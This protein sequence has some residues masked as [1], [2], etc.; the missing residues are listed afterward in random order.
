MAS[1][2]LIDTSVLVAAANTRETRH[3]EAARALSRLEGERAVI[4][5]TILTET[6]GF[7][8]TRYGLDHHRR[9][10]ASLRASSIEVFPADADLLE[11]A[12]RIDE[13]YADVGYGFADCTLLASCEALRTARVLSFDRR[14]AAYRPS[15]ASALEVMP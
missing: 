13:R 11:E 2:T 12:R 9:L 6:L 15:F 14:L 7:V 1:S 5:I 8:R 3:V 4:P 10:W